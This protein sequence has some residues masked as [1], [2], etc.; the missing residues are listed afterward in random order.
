M[1]TAVSGYE[2]FEKLIP[3]EAVTAGF[4]TPGEDRIADREVVDAALPWLRSGEYELVLIHLDQV[5]YAGHHEG[6]AAD[7]NWDA[8]AQ[9]VG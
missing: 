4:Y 2:W 6:G 9:T 8:A 7:P 3:A 5:D 1:Q